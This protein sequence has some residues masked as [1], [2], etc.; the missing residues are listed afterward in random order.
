MSQAKRNYTMT[1]A[2]QQQRK[3][4]AEKKHIISQVPEL[5]KRLSLCSDQAARLQYAV[6]QASQIFTLKDLIQMEPYKAQYDALKKSADT[7]TINELRNRLHQ[8]MSENIVLLRQHQSLLE[9]IRQ[10]EEKSSNNSDD[11]ITMHVSMGD[12]IGATNNV[13]DDEFDDDDQSIF[14]V[15]DEGA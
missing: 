11:D 14:S 5:F 8:S 7:K 6:T 10:D 4:A 1:E 13:T 2:V 12:A 15:I 9:K 3:N